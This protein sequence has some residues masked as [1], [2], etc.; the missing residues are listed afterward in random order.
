MKLQTKED[1][2]AEIEKLENETNMEATYR[3]SAELKEETK[4]EER[5]EVIMNYYFEL[6]GQPMTEA[7]FEIYDTCFKKA[8]SG[9]NI[10]SFLRDQKI[11]IVEDLS[12]FDEFCEKEEING[13]L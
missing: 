13:N 3:I 2:L 11:K 9:Y 8:E 1:E 12:T 4:K 5:R 10:K 6:V 7:E